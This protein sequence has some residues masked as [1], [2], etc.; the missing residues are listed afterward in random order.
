[1]ARQFNLDE[2]E[3]VKERKAKFYTDYP[4]GSIV[5]DLVNP[6]SL[7][8]HAIFKASVYESKE[9][10]LNL[11]PRGVGYALEV[12]DTELKTSGAGNKYESV[13]FTSWTENAEESAVGRA[14]DNAGYS[15]N[16]KPSQ[17]EMKKVVRHSEILNNPTGQ[18]TR[19]PVQNAVDT[20]LDFGK[21]PI[22]DEQMIQRTSNSTGKLYTS[23]ILNGK[24]CFGK[25]QR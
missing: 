3:T 22:H 13:N 5:V 10:Q 12:R 16:K 8:T 24:H 17:E 4:K 2:Y 18:I 6:E 21:C 25:E 23:H 20:G 9:D 11:T 15:G 14:L 7:K 1:M 19:E